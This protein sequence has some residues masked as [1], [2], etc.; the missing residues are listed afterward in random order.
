MANKPDKLSKM[1]KG[2]VVKIGSQ[3]YTVITDF[4]LKENYTI[5]CEISEDE[6]VTET[7][8]KNMYVITNKDGHVRTA[9]EELVLNSF[10]ICDEFDKNFKLTAEVTIWDENK[11][12]VLKILP[13]E[14]TM[15]ES[16]QHIHIT[17]IHQE[18]KYPHTCPYCGGQAYLGLD[19]LD[20]K[21]GC[22]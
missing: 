12:V 16:W 11:N 10:D 9:S 4:I 2:R 15:Y 6:Y 1:T 5:G 8:T 22:R 3:K 21:N 7:L 17:S 19:S 14:Q 18:N 13:N 20:C